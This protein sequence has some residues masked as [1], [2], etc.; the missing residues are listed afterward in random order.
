LPLGALG[1]FKSDPKQPDNSVTLEQVIAKLVIHGSPS[2]VADQLHALKQETGEF[3]TLLYAGVDW[4]DRELARNSMVL[5][6]EKVMP[7]MNA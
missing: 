3:G 4:T 2:K 5:M 7:R 6:A 1:V